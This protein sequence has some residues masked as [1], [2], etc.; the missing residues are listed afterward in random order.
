VLKMFWGPLDNPKNKHLP[1]LTRREAISLAPLV[2]L[3]FAI[4]FFPRV[5][6]EPMHPTVESFVKTFAE[7]RS[8]EEKKVLDYAFVE[9]KQ[10][11][12]AAAAAPGGGQ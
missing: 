11:T 4:G 3:I 5:F 7:R 10:E 9:P 6:T 8:I 12:T 1:D 2:V